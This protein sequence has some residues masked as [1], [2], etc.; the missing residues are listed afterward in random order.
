[1]GL[2]NGNNPYTNSAKSEWS[3]NQWYHIAYVDLGNGTS[4]LVY[5]DG[6]LDTNS[7][8]YPYRFG[9]SDL[10]FGQFNALPPFQGDID[11]V[12][13][14]DR[15]LSAVEAQIGAR[16]PVMACDAVSSVATAANC[17]AGSIRAV[18]DIARCMLCS[19]GAYASLGSTQC[20]PCAAG[21]FQPNAGGQECYRCDT[22]TTDGIS[23]DDTVVLDPTQVVN[24]TELINTTHQ[25]VAVGLGRTPVISLNANISLANKTLDVYVPLGSAVPGASVVVVTYNKTLA[26]VSVSAPYGT[27]NVT[28]VNAAVAGNTSCPPL[29]STAQMSNDTAFVVSLSF[30][31]DSTCLLTPTNLGLIIGMVFLAMGLLCCCA[32][33]AVLLYRCSKKNRADSSGV[34]EIRASAVQPPSLRIDDPFP[35]PGQRACNSYFILLCSFWKF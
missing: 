4:W 34:N 18:D 5:I 22:M 3:P 24:A 12:V 23:C 33:V 29:I 11:E 30:E 28:L 10:Q 6:F 8:S 32:I 35:T 21:Y 27:V 13:I 15:A 9:S 20:L 26:N 25:I 17:A 7:T 16:V 14:V 19:M 31:A 1:L 2:Y